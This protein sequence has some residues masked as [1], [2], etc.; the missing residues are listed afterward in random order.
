VQTAVGL[1]RST[2]RAN[3]R[4]L[5][6]TSFIGMPTFR[7]V[8]ENYPCSSDSDAIGGCMTGYTSHYF[9]LACRDFSPRISPVGLN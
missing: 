8:C 7:T 9:R 5:R 1:F 3:L 6:R 2:R 4:S